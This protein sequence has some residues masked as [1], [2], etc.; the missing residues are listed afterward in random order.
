MNPAIDDIRRLSITEYYGETETHKDKVKTYESGV[1]LPNGSSPTTLLKADFTYDDCGR[2]KTQK[3]Q[4]LLNSDI[5]DNTHAFTYDGADN[6]LFDDHRQVI[7]GTH[8]FDVTRRI[9]FANRLLQVRQRFDA[10]G[11]KVI[12]HNTYNEKDLI[13]K[14]RIGHV[15]GSTYLQTCDYTYLGN[16]FLSKINQ[17]LTSSA[18]LFHLELKYDSVLPSSGASIQNNGNIS[19]V[20]SQLKGQ[21]RLSLGLKYDNYNRLLFSQS[22]NYDN[23]G[24]FSSP[25]DYNSEYTYDDRGNLVTLK[26][27]GQYPNGNVFDDG[28][29]DNLTFTPYPNSN[30]IKTMADATA[31]EHKVRGCLLYTSDAADE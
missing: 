26:R 12:V 15:S 4:S 31:S 19:Q 8:H 25:G 2:L 22:I 1:L 10:L 21:E 23:S 20:L 6:L 5:E 30:R 24:G 17:E 7:A 28:Q 29:I 13:A 14:E 3:S 27:E 18:D 11:T 9:D 16:Q